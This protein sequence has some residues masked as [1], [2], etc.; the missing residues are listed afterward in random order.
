MDATLHVYKKTLNCASNT[1]DVKLDS[2]T[3]Y[4]DYTWLSYYGMDVD[5]ISSKLISVP[6]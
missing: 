1:K 2:A 5:Y 6:W 4:S 3:S